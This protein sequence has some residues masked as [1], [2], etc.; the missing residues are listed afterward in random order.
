MNDKPK[1]YLF[2][3]ILGLAAGLLT[4]LLDFFPCKNIWTFSSFSGSLGFWAFTTSVIVYLSD[5][6][7][8]AGFNTFIYLCSMSIAF[9][10]FKGIVS[11]YSGYTDFVRDYT[12]LAVMWII[13]SFVCGFLGLLVWYAKK[14]GWFSSFIF[15]LPISVML[16]EGIEL[17]MKQVIAKH[18]YLFQTIF[19]FV[20]SFILFWCFSNKQKKK[21]AIIFIIPL[22]IVFCLAL[23]FIW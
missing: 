21:Q 23:F 1:S 4:V 19:N 2:V 5:K 12:D 3:L 22:T 11:Y 15:A 17:L 8:T 20:F 6:M 9:Y 14:D 18:R 10:V 16:T 7:K 13:I